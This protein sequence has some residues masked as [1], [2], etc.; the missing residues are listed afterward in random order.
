[1]KSCRTRCIARDNQ[2]Y[3][4]HHQTML[5]KAAVISTWLTDIC[6]ETCIIL[7]VWTYRVENKALVFPNSPGHGLTSKI[8]GDRVQAILTCVGLPP[9]LS[10]VISMALRE[11]VLTNQACTEFHPS[12]ELK[13]NLLWNQQLQQRGR[14][15]DAH[16]S[17]SHVSQ[18][19]KEE[20]KVWWGY[21]YFSLRKVTIATDP[22]PRKNP[23]SSEQEDSSQQQVMDRLFS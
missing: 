20:T 11:S 5:W 19:I 17:A 2:N 22:W 1:M 10:W 8:D 4:Q 23:A 12:S 9:M 3:K 6:R 7:T 14:K 13:F 21:V 18:E 15:Q 16:P